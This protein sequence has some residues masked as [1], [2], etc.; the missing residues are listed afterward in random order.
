M[1][2][3]GGSFKAK[4]LAINKQGLTFK[5]APF[6]KRAASFVLDLFVL[7]LLVF[8]HFQGLFSKAVRENIGELT[9]SVYLGVFFASIISLLYFALLEHYAQQT[10]GM[11]LVKLY[12]VPKPGFWKAV[13][14]NLFVL[15]FFPFTL[16]WVIEPLHLYF[17]KKRF[18]ELLTRTDT[19][20]VGF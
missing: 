11:M 1:D 17:K 3:V 10:L 20:E 9:P 12:A 15:P 6:W 18:L 13:A 4:V 8:T 14:R 19:V 5:T 2:N 7:N 16:L